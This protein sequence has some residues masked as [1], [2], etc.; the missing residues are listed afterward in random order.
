MSKFLNSNYK[1]IIRNLGYISKK[2]ILKKILDQVS[3]DHISAHFSLEEVSQI[4]FKYIGLI[5]AEGLLMYI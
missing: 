4:K 3:R 1:I 2:I 5:K